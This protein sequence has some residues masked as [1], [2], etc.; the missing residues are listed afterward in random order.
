MIRALWRYRHFVVAS[1]VSDLRGRF[2]GSKL[3]FLWAVLNPLAQAAIYTLV[4][5]EILGARIPGL[6][7][8]VAYP[9]YLM[10]GLAAWGLFSE[11]LTRSV[12][13]FI[14]YATPLKKIAFPRSSLPVIVAGGA[15]I[16]H[17]LLLVAVAAVL[18]LF[19]YRPTVAWAALPVGAILIVG[20]SIGLGLILGTL[21]VFVRDIA[22]V[23]GVVAQ[24]WFWLTPVV[25]LFDA[26]PEHF[27]FL[28]QVNPM[29]PLVKIYQDAILYGTWPSVDS[30]LIP[31][32]VSSFVLLLALFVFRRARTDLVDAL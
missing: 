4:L 10:A 31:A 6:S 12:V 26:V 30:L 27:R 15:I 14:D 19:G 13:I 2:A 9:T 29:T 8:R 3:G 11:I 20:L 1:V 5:A 23:I 17:L 21:N 22:Q 7:D 32:V 18:L 16:N 25:Y 24:I 28:M